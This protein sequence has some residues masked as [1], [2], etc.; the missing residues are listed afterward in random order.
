MASKGTVSST[1]KALPSGFMFR[2]KQE[3]SGPTVKCSKWQIEGEKQNQ[4][5]Q[6]ICLRPVPQPK[7]KRERKLAV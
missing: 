2:E 1:G 4:H 7:K 6:V 5:P 3:T